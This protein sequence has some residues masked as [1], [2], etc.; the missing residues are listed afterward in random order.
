M[1]RTIEATWDGVVLRIDGTLDL[2]ADHRVR[3]VSVRDAVIGAGGAAGRV[4]AVGRTPI[5]RYRSRRV[6]RCSSTLCMLWHGTH[7]NRHE[8]ESASGINRDYP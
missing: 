3:I 4:G 1:T 7:G 2:L 6:K 8:R 5:W